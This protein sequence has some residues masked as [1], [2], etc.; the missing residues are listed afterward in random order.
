[1]EEATGTSSRRGLLGRAAVLAAGAVGVQAGGAAA[2]ASPTTLR[3]YAGGVHLHSPSH[4]PGR[5]P[6]KGE[7]FTTYGELLDAPGGR[8]IGSFAA[9]F[10]A[11]DSPFAAGPGSQELHTFS[12]AD[13]TI[14]GL[15]TATAGTASEFAIIG[16]TGRY[17]GVRGSYVAHQQPRELGGNGTAEFHLTL[18]A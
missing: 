10:F 4:R 3:L 17:S 9:A 15:G 1:M 2:A 14:L 8:S 13:G 5:V 12:L 16:G 6:A 18:V 11:L 7:R